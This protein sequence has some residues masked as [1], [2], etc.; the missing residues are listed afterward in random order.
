MVFFQS[1]HFL[2][3]RFLHLLQ[4]SSWSFGFEAVGFSGDLQEPQWNIFDC[5]MLVLIASIVA[6]F[7][8]AWLLARGS[9]KFLC[10]QD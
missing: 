2:W 7:S 4:D 6:A 8:V 3:K 9:R 1:V 5:W 10:Y